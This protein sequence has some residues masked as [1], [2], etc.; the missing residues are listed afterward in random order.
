MDE[1]EDLSDFVVP[2]V[3]DNKNYGKMLADHYG[4]LRM[5]HQL[6]YYSGNWK[7]TRWLGKEML[8]SPLD[9]WLY[10][11]ILFELKPDLVV[12]TGT[13]HGGS[14]YFMASLMDVVG[15]GRVLSIDIEP[16]PDL[17]R[18]DRI[19]FRAGSS[20]DPAIAAEVRAAAASAQSVMVVLDSAHNA[21]HVLD[22]MRLYGD[23]VTPGGYLIVEDS[24]VN[25]HP[26]VPDYQE[27]GLAPVGGP[28]EAIGDF[29]AERDDFEIDTDKH[30]YMLT[31]N[32]NGYLRK[33]AMP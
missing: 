33:R 32:P 25:G 5:F 31:F 17:P 11:E 10:Q 4:V 8:K 24:N 2:L 20:L 30:R 3:N 19:T 21:P 18:H 27:P 23:L 12:E 29:L 9:M 22:E 28:M 1:R 7:N 6:F 26:V 16:G 15:R 14:A 13:W